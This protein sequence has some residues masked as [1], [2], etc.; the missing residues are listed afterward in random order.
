MRSQNAKNKGKRKFEARRNSFS[1][2]ETRK[3]SI[4]FIQSSLASE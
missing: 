3:A 4:A 1:Y 2:F